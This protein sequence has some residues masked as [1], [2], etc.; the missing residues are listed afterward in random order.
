MNIDVLLFHHASDPVTLH[1]YQALKDCNSHD[2]SV[3]II[4]IGFA[5]YLPNLLPGSYV[6]KV[7]EAFRANPSPVF[8][9]FH[10]PMGPLIPDLDCLVW[11]Y[12]LYSGQQADRIVI[13][14]GDMLSRCSIREFFGPS[15]RHAV[16][17]STVRTGV[18]ENKHWDWYKRT[19]ENVRSLLGN[20]VASLTPVCGIQMSW[21]AAIKM[22]QLVYRCDGLF[23]NI[24]V[25]MAIGTLARMIGEDP[26]PTELPGRSRAVEFINWRGES[27][28]LGPWGIYHPVKEILPVRMDDD[29]VSPYRSR[30]AFSGWAIGVDDYDWLVS[31]CKDQN[32]RRVMEF[33]PGDSTQA[34]LDAG[35]SVLS[36]ESD[37][38]WHRTMLERFSND[39]PVSLTFYLD[40]AGCALPEPMETFDLVFV[41]GPPAW[42]EGSRRHTLAWAMAHADNV[43]LHDARRA[44]E[45]QLLSGISAD[46]WVVTHIPTRKGMALL[47]RLPLIPPASAASP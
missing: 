23:D 15:F 19:P 25:E 1:H 14:E 37:P 28:Q 4:P 38:E 40:E 24:H 26:R 30:A 10:H 35:C 17:G 11:D 31:W 5:E 33:G 32:V 13:A 34:F 44:G 8:H 12:V 46:E 2:S 42:N 20:N 45:L 3:R 9:R 16:T 29:E 39:D 18:A 22:A 41:D 43:V 27:L 47:Q 6:P 36:A 7:P 21:E